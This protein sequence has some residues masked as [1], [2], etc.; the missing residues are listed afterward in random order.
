MLRIQELRLA[1]D[2]QDDDLRPAIVN[3]LGIADTELL[4]FSIHRRGY[5]ARN[6]RLITFIY[7]LDVELCNEQAVLQRLRDDAQIGPTPDM[8]YRPGARAPAPPA[9][10]PVG[11][12]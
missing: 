10:P 3:R 1:L 9:G 4:S 2:H 5:D 11:V 7:T 6:K 12:A 8:Q